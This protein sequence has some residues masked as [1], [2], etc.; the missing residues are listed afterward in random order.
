MN[1]HKSIWN[2]PQTPVIV[3]N[4]LRNKWASI[5]RHLK[6]NP[7]IRE[8]YGLLKVNEFFFIAKNNRK[9]R[10]ESHLDW[11]FYEPKTLAQAIDANTV[12]SYYEI[13]LND[14][15]SDP[16]IWKD[17]D[18]EMELKSYYAARKNRADLI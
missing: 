16:N 18:L 7:N 15:R 6:T 5:K 11:T 4:Q 14:I 12:E 17:R 1:P 2:V 8:C 9:M 10:L 3:D 13:M